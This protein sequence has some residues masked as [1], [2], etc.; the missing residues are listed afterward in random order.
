MV[1]VNSMFYWLLID[2]GLVVDLYVGLCEV[3]VA[4][5]VV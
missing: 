5:N 3:L 4:I 1:E 2:Y